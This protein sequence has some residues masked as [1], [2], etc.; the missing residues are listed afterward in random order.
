MEVA[1]NSVMITIG[2]AQWSLELVA[3][4]PVG[5]IGR[6]SGMPPTRSKRNTELDKI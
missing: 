5:R 3:H 1:M 6:I 4:K 2:I